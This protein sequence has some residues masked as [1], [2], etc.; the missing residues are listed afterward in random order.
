M[1]GLFYTRYVF[2]AGVNHDEVEHAHVGFKILNG[3]IPYRDF[4]Q[5]HMPAYWLVTMLTVSAFPFSLKAILAARGLNLL[6][7]LGCWA[8]GLR[9]LSGFRG[10]RTWLG[11]G[12]YTCVLLVVAYEMNFHLARP[13]PLMTFLAMASLSVIPFRGRV[14]NGCALLVG[15][16]FG[17]SALVSTKVIPFALVLPA[18]LVVHCKRDGSWKPLR[19]VIPYVIG[20]LLGLLP[21]MFWL[22]RHDLFQPFWFDVIELNRA[23]SKPWRECF[24]T[25]RAN[26]VP[27][28]ALGYFGFA[29]ESSEAG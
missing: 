14:G 1:L 4:Y 12:V 9:L 23:L 7:L 28:G 24:Q 16:L 11:I 3:E 15:L 20:G 10:G 2:I 21:L 22:F 17:F 26:H 29:A 13:D 6:M 5:N 27:G 25:V 18:L 19:T 8:I